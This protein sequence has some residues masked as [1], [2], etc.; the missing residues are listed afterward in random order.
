VTIISGGQI[1]SVSSGQTD[2]GTV[3]SGG[4]LVVSAGGTTIDSGGYESVLSGGSD[5]GT[6]ISG[7]TLELSSGAAARSRS[8]QRTACCGL[9]ARRCQRT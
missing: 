6:I 9:T 5:G 2:S 8:R 1:L 7:G 3:L 4:D